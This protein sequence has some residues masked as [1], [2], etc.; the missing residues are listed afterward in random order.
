M[1]LQLKNANT[2]SARS[3]AD[4]PKPAKSAKSG[5]AGKSFAEGEAALK[6]GGAVDTARAPKSGGAH[7]D[8]LQDDYI[9]YEFIHE[10]ATNMGMKPP[11]IAEWAK[12]KDADK[13]F[14]RGLLDGPLNGGEGQ[15][16]PEEVMKLYDQ[17]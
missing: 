8:P 9:E 10:A 7:C 6:P 4:G 16:D 12:M 14:W 11:T 5:L 17:Q 3:K 13:A 2:K 1:E 15:R